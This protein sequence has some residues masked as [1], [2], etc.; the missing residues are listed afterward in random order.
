MLTEGRS[1]LLSSHILAEVEQLCDR[2]TIIRQGRSVQSGSLDELRLLTR[3]TIKAETAQSATALAQLPGVHNLKADDGHV[4]F[5]VDSGDLDAVV[6]ELGRFGVRSLV[7]HPP[8]LE[9]L[10]LRH[11]G[12]VVENHGS[13]YG[14]GSWGT[15]GADSTSGT[16]S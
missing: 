5:E 9:E 4:S 12:D 8:T 6:R 14:A 7:S 13:D 3:T 11:Y 15:A 2:V 1:V 10:F 16:S